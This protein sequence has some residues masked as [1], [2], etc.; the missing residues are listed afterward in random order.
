MFQTS[1]AP[2]VLS[3][4]VEY[5]GMSRIMIIYDQALQL[6]YYIQDVFGSYVNNSKFF[7]KE[8]EKQIFQK[9]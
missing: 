8:M 3:Q 2:I 4:P 7:I 5:K 6:I 9:S 1:S